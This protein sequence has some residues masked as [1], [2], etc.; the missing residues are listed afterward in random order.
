[1]VEVIILVFSILNLIFLGFVFYSIIIT[2]KNLSELINKFDTFNTNFLADEEE[3]KR[4]RKTTT[5]ALQKIS[6]HL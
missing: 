5:I 2:N 1:M 4:I 6:E 3:S